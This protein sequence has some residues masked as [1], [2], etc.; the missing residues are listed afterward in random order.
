MV[1]CG[2]PSPQLAGP[3]QSVGVHHPNL[4]G[5]TNEWESINPTEGAMAKRGSPSLQLQGPQR[6]VGVHHPNLRGHTEVRESI[7]AT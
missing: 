2:S 5:H 4:R 7:T 1:E 3:C 6:S